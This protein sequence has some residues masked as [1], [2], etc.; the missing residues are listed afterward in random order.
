MPPTI[1]VV[2]DDPAL[3]ELL[4]Y[5]LTREGF[6]VALAADGDAALAAAEDSLPDL[7][8]LD[9]MIPGLSGIEVCRRLRRRQAS[10]AL[11]VIMLTA[12]G[13]ETD[14]IEGLESGADDYVVKPFSI[15]E[16]TARIR[17]VLRRAGT[18]SSA[19][20]ESEAIEAGG[21]RLDLARH[22]VTRAGR[23]VHLGPTEFKL[24]RVLMERPGRVFGREQLLDRVWG[25][26]IH[27]ELRTV[28]AQVRR[29]R[30]ALNAAGAEDVIRTVRGAGYAFEAEK[31]E[32]GKST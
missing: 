32:V 5:N 26:D 30:R 8:V 14:R 9:W 28:D 17:A 25:R 27:V 12:R 4:R 2:E 13:E 10:R 1:L 21:V 20:A 22:R 3:A 23:E 6:E 16:L 7:V 11:P 18:G 19:G 15:A 29:L 31:S 24:L